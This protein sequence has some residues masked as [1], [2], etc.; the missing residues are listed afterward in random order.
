MIAVIILNKSCNTKLFTC[1]NSILDTTKDAKFNIY[2]GDTGSLPQELANIE[3]FIKSKQSKYCDTKIHLINIGPYNYAKNTNDIVHNY[4]NGEEY[5]VFCNNDIQFRGYI[6][7]EFMRANMQLI[8]SNHKVGTIGCR[9][10]YPNGLIQHDGQFAAYV[11]PG[12][13]T[14]NS[15]IL[16][17]HNNIGKEPFDRNNTGPIVFE[18][19]KPIATEVM[20]NTFALCFVSSKLF[21]DAG[22][23]DE[24]YQHCFE[25]L[26]FNL[27]LR[28]G[29]A[30]I[31]YTNF[32]LRTYQYYAIH[33]ESYSRKKFSDQ[34]ISRQDWQKLCTFIRGNCS[35]IIR[36][37]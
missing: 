15:Q 17:G 35:K 2:I 33:D 20:G 27:Q 36:K 3:A 21:L 24:S 9:L 34:Y 32:L 26:Q 4:L 28:V 18:N 19:D 1:I 8:E 10:M 29:V 7:S 6:L 31:S 16:V 37:I 14:S 22:G 11:G 13:L 23:L 5:L 30:G 12:E 25:D